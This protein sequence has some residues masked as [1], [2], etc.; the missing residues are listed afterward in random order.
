MKKFYLSKTLWFNFL[1]LVTIIAGNFGYGEFVAQA[2][3][4]D[5]GVSLVILVNLI[6]RFVTKEGIK[7]R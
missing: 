7:I 6:L 1:A 2:W 3:V 5:L 4:N